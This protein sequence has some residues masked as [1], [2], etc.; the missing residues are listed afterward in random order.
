MVTIGF[1]QTSA[2]IA[3]AENVGNVTIHVIIISGTL[4]RELSVD[5]I[6]ENGSALGMVLYNVRRHDDKYQ[7]TYNKAQFQIQVV[8]ILAQCIL[9]YSTI[10]YAIRILLSL[11]F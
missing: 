6:P 7:S 11:Y 2:S 10:E 8:G 5:I 4:E 3:V 1:E 9:V